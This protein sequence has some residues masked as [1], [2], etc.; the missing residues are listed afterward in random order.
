MLLRFLGT[1]NME[2]KETRLPCILVDDILA[3]DAG[4]LV[5]EL[6]LEEQE[7]VRSILL[8]HGHYDHVRGVPAFAFNNYTRTTRV[9]GTQQTLDILSSHLIDGI[10]YPKLSQKIG[11]EQRAPLELVPLDTSRPRDIEGYSVLAIP[12]N[13][14]LGAVGFTITS[15]E[16]K[17]VF[18]SGD[19]GPGLGPVWRSISPD[20]IITDCTFPNRL[21]HMANQSGHLCPDMLRDELVE[22]RKI[23]G[24]SP[25]V[26]LIHVTPQLEAE[27]RGELEETTRSSGV[28]IRIAQEGDILTL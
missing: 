15:G 3:L 20:L 24:Y 21:K 13:H 5:S 18:Y 9:Y 22:F 26:V 2:S 8:T 14:P 27:I 16:G 12:V 19:T 17:S 23:R 7:K 11:P 28:P 1:H 10:I 6:S 25:Q 4:S